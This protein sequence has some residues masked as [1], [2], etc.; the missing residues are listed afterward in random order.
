MT[1]TSRF[2]VL[3]WA[4]NPNFSGRIVVA[5]ASFR[6]SS[7]MNSNT[8]NIVFNIEIS[9]WL[10]GCLTYFPVFSIITIVVDCAFLPLY[11]NML[12]VMLSNFGAFLPGSLRILLHISDGKKK[13]DLT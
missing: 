2:V 5:V 8:L 9:R 6:S 3:C 1:L 4:Q 13:I 11:L 7:S 12:L 10:K